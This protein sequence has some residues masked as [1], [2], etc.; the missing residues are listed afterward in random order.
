[1]KLRRF[2][3]AGIKAF[4]EELALLRANPDRDPNPQ[5]LEH[6]ELTEIALPETE[7]AEEFFRTKGEAARYFGMIFRNHRSEY[8]EGDAGLWTWLSCFFIDSVCPYAGGKRSVKSDYFYIY[9]PRNMRNFYR[10]LLYVSWRVL[11]LA[12]VHNRL[13]LTTRVDSLDS[14]TTEVMQRLYLLRIP[15]IFE[16]VD[17]LYWDEKNGRPSKGRIR[18][19]IQPG[20]LRYR[21]PVRIRQ[22]E[23]TY[24]LLSLN[25][26]QLIE[27]LGDEFS[28]ARPKTARLFEDVPG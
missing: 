7:I 5:L 6:R 12:P 21:L 8:I 9:E 22:L 14:A 17:R 3:E 23:K 18:S 2:N 19:A 27:L 25:A 10:H 1:M 11:R 16:V 15:S 28:F 4:R 26:D 24:D 13:F 20:N